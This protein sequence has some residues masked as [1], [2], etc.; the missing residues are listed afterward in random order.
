[1]VVELHSETAW[2]N[3]EL[4]QAQPGQAGGAGSP[5]QVGQACRE[6]ARASGQHAGGAA[7]GGLVDELG[8]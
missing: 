3:L 4:D 2:R 5:G 6:L 8:A 1:M 7:V